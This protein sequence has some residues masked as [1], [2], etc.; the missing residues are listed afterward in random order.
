MGFFDEKKNVEEYMRMADGYDGKELIEKLQKYLPSG[1]N[2]LEIGMGPGVDLDLLSNN[3]EVTGSDLSL[4]FIDLYREKHPEADL[5]L[6]DA[7]KLSTSRT[8]DCLY[9][10]K[11]L[12]HLTGEQLEDS[13]LNQMKILEPGGLVLHS[14]WYGEGS[15][16]I[17]D[18]LFTYYK[19]D[20]ILRLIPDDFELLEMER[21]TEFE[22]E[23]SFYIILKNKISS[24]YNCSYDIK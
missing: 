23:D 8:F 22:K 7:V 3:Y 16:K 24:C 11:V 14:F 6:L 10:N 13:F 18:L 2:V 19:P 4:V 12:H 1:K 17:E 5:L 20:D 9:S 15:E 21:Y